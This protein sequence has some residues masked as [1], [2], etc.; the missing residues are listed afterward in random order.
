MKIIIDEEICI[1][2]GT[3]EMMCGQCFKLEGNVAKVIKEDC[4]DPDLNEIANDCPVQAI[5]IK[6]EKK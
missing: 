5:K 2:C 3:C 4:E 6:T 1:G